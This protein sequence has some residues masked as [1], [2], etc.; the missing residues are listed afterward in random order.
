VRSTS[1][2]T[3]R[4][5]WARWPGPGQVRVVGPDDA[6]DGLGAVINWA[7]LRCN[8]YIQQ[9][10]SE[11]T[12]RC[13]GVYTDPLHTYFF[14]KKAVNLTSSRFY[15]SV[16]LITQLQHS[17]QSITIVVIPHLQHI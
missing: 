7:T 8:I 11:H 3:S 13:S 16:L 12:L 2:A 1:G 5:E 4:R 14:S 6:R 15:G 17:K 10:C 9:L